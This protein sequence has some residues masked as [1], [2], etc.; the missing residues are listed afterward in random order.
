MDDSEP[1]PKG[2]LVIKASFEDRAPTYNHEARKAIDRVKSGESTLKEVIKGSSSP[3]R[4]IIEEVL[5]E[6][7]I[8]ADYQRRLRKA[9]IT[10]SLTAQDRV[11]VLA[12]A[13]LSQNEEGIGADTG[14]SGL[15]KETRELA[16]EIM[17]IKMKRQK[18]QQ[19]EMEDLDDS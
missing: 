11:E 1:T 18:K 14:A 6:Y 10:K 17:K 9:Q 5:R 16:Q 19:E 3:A 7:E 15:S 2:A 4:R 13:K 8:P 12:A